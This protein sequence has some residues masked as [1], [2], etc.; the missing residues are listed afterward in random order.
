TPIKNGDIDRDS[1]RRLIRFQ[2]DNG[3]NGFVI[4]GTTGESPTL[5]RAEKFEVFDFVKSET[6]GQVPLVMGT[7]SN[8]TADSIE[9]TKAA[10]ERGADAALVVVPYYNKPPQRG[11]F[12]HFQKIAECSS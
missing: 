11:L 2:L 6:A 1:L 12:Q 9:M 7:G 5:S 4:C 3:V 8:S 10:A